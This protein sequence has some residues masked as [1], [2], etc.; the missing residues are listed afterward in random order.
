M[1]MCVFI[2]AVSNNSLIFSEEVNLKIPFI[3]LDPSEIL[4]PKSD[5]VNTICFLNN[6][7]EINNNSYLN[8]IWIVVFLASNLISND[9]LNKL[10]KNK[11]QLL[12]IQIL[13]KKIKKIFCYTNID[14]LKNYLSMCDLNLIIQK[15]EQEI[16]I[17]FL[18][19]IDIYSK[20]K[21]HETKNFKELNDWIL[22]FLEILYIIA[23]KIENLDLWYKLFFYQLKKNTVQMKFNN[24]SFHDERYTVSFNEDDCKKLKIFDKQN[25]VSNK[26]LEKPIPIN[27]TFFCN[28][29]STQEFN[30]SKNHKTEEPSIN[31]NRYLSPIQQINDVNNSDLSSKNTF[32]TIKQYSDFNQNKQNNSYI[33]LT[34]T[35]NQHTP[36]KEKKDVSFN[37]FQTQNL[38]KNM[39]LKN[40]EIQL[41]EFTKIFNI[42]H[43]GD[44]DIH[45]LS[46]FAQFY[47]AIK[48]NINNNSTSMISQL[49]T[50]INYA[51]VIYNN[52]EINI[53]KEVKSN[54]LNNPYNLTLGNIC[55]CHPRSD[56]NLVEYLKN[57]KTKLFESLVIFS[58][59]IYSQECQQYMK[60]LYIFT[61]FLLS[62][63]NSSS[64]DFK[65]YCFSEKMEL[66]S[67]FISTP[68]EDNNCL[69][70][71]DFSLEIEHIET[72]SNKNSG[73][74]DFNYLS[75]KILNNTNSS[76]IHPQLNQST[77]NNLI[78]ILDTK[79]HSTSVYFKKKNKVRK[80]IF[81]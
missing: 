60:F 28:N 44:L 65:K 71:K 63:F 73:K 4:D 59:V 56:K 12:N 14:A 80:K 8:S 67:L 15:K 18:R 21:K 33:N 69:Y 22:N 16:L 72:R 29:Y 38:N 62:I 61:S 70:T 78:N 79:N 2:K 57:V 11:N 45:K 41:S 37:I 26:K 25:K 1:N 48:F 19:N 51:M 10:K 77:D 27:T 52:F 50:I 24:L 46:Y 32:F 49:I 13:K 30:L 66:F 23:F 36:Q 39:E 17:N 68:V 3:P 76:I 7:V 20:Q 40:K 9:S 74:V 42:I 43:N 64:S 47:D 34:T 6:C 75:M 5:I 35:L 81:S 53:I 55:M 31:E 54:N 58:R